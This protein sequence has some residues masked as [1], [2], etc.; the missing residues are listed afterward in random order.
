M[1]KNFKILAIVAVASLGCIVG[2]QTLWVKQENIKSKL[3]MANVEAL[4]RSEDIKDCDYYCVQDPNFA[5]VLSY[6]WGTT[7]CLNKSKRENS[8]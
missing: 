3:V 4:T 2:I 7:Y 5:C 6:S 8:N 1:K